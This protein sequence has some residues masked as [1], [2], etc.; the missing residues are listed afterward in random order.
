MLAILA[1]AV[2]IAVVLGLVLGLRPVIQDKKSYC[3]SPKA[4][5]TKASNEKEHNRRPAAYGNYQMAAV[6]A[7]HPDCSKIG[8]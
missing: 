2:L 8:T 4:P 3:S 7:D 6:Q 5:A 1:G